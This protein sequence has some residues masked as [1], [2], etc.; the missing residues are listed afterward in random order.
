MN[1]IDLELVI[2]L[3]CVVSVI[4]LMIIFIG[5]KG[6]VVINLIYPFFFRVLIDVLRLP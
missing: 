3:I 6:W 4:G 2:V 1:K 5:L